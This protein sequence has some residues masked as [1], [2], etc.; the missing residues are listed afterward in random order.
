[1]FGLE[2]DIFTRPSIDFH[3]YLFAKIFPDVS[4]AFQKIFNTKSKNCF[5]FRIHGHL[6]SKH[7]LFT[8]A[9]KC[10]SKMFSFR[11]QTSVAIKFYKLTSFTKLKNLWPFLTSYGKKAHNLLLPRFLNSK[12]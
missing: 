12:S 8:I 2:D 4:S 11:S 1:M 6:Y 3:F 10:A 7:K 9:K 5:R